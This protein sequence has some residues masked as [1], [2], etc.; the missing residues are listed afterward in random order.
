MLNELINRIL[1]RKKYYVHHWQATANNDRKLYFWSLKGAIKYADGLWGK[2][3]V[4]RTDHKRMYVKKNEFPHVHA[5]A[6]NFYT[7]PHN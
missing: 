4:W 7:Y 5:D 2:R 3:I 1:L 6:N